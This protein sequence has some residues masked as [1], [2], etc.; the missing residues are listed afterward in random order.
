MTCRI[1]RARI[2]ARIRNARSVVA[3]RLRASETQSDR[4]VEAMNVREMLIRSSVR[5]LVQTLMS[6]K[7]V[8][9]FVFSNVEKR[10][11]E[12]ARE[13]SSII[14]PKQAM[15][16][17]LD[18]ASALLHGIDRAISRGIVSRRVMRYML[19]AFLGNVLLN[20]DSAARAKELGFE[21]PSFVTISPTG[22]CNLKCEGCY[23]S[24]AALAGSQ[25]DYSTFDRILREKRDMWG[26]H[27]T[28][29]SG[30]EPLLWKDGE[31]D[32]PTLAAR[33][34]QDVFM[35][36]TNGT[37]V[38]DEMARRLADTGNVSLAISVEGFEAETDAR[39]GRGVHAK[40]LRAF[41]NLRNHGVPFG[42]SATALRHN[43]DTI[44][45]DEFVDYYFF[46]QGAIYA[47]VFQYMPIGRGQTM[48]L[49]VPP[50]ARLQMVERMWRLVRERKVFM[51]DFWNSGT[52]S[53]GCI[54]AGRGSG[55]FYINWDG[56][57]MPCVF[58][59]YASDNIHD[60]YAR[61]EDLNAAIRSPLFERIREWQHNYGYDRPALEVDNWIC[62]CVIRDHF[63]V[64][65]QAIKECGGRPIN[66]EA[67]QAIE[68]PDYHER[69]VA[70]GREFKRLTDEKWRREYLDT[71]GALPPEPEREPEAR[72]H[73]AR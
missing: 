23:A 36:Y 7:Q 46:D 57:V 42:V 12:E 50:Q 15:Q 64:F 62:P 5:V 49:V 27:F 35:V 20:E 1:G 2:A 37:L 4:L 19:D 53:M 43:W 71:H 44:V 58:A 73:S 51:V 39:R 14:F 33:H 41:E 29:I 68:D 47:W 48:D 38:D 13:S 17:R 10:L 56:D 70:Y 67:R 61:G 40:I 72:V 16:D 63:E 18:C 3:V 21:P 30:G 6:N 22:R 52:A 34:P 59:P 26:S 8:R 65:A 9:R 69:M 66:E 32:L 60:I 24:D 55:Y 28:V 25:L 45:S 54:S 11:Y 31:V